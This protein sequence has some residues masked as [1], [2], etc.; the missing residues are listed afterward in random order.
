MNIDIV[1]IDDKY[2][3]HICTA[4][5]TALW[6]GWG[7]FIDLPIEVGLAKKIVLGKGKQ[8]AHF[9]KCISALGSMLIRP[10]TSKAIRFLSFLRARDGISPTCFKNYASFVGF[11]FITSKGFLPLYCFMHG[12]WYCDFPYFWQVALLCCQAQ[13]IKETV[14]PASAVLGCDL[15]LRCSKRLN[16]CPFGAWPLESYVFYMFYH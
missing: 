13:T 8:I 10:R 14:L 16:V 3:N 11:I 2:K 15:S 6:S 5:Y 7:Q 1:S 9:S 12:H 4:Y